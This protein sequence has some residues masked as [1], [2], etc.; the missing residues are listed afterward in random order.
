MF[1]ASILSRATCSGFFGGQQKAT[2]RNRPSAFFE[3]D[4]AVERSRAT[5]QRIRATL[6]KFMRNLRLHTLLPRLLLPAALLAGLDARADAAGAGGA[7]A[8][9]SRAD[10]FWQ[11]MAGHYGTV[12]SALVIL[13]QIAGVVSAIR[14]ILTARTSQGA[15]AWVVALLLLPYIAVPAYWVFGRS[16]FHG[17]VSLRRRRSA[18]TAPAIQAAIIHM[19]AQNMLVAPRFGEPFA[20]ER[21][22]N[23]PLT[24]ANDAEL[25]V[26]GEATFASIF[27]GIDR[28]RDYVLVQFY[29]IHDDATGRELLAR[30]AARAREGTRCFVLY[31]EL[32]SSGLTSRYVRDARAAGVAITKFNTRRGR[33]NRFQI[34]FRNHR[35]IV[36]VDGAEAWVGGLNVGDEYRGLD[37]KIGFWRDTHLR[38]AGPVVQCAQAAFVDDWHWATGEIPRLEWRPRAAPGGVSRVALCLPSAPSD[39]LETATLFFLD[40]INAARR[41]VWIATP[42]FVPDEQFISAL[43]LASLH[44]VDVRILIPDKA[45]N[46]LVQLSAWA[47]IEA[48]EAAGI[49]TFRYMKGFM[50]H[51]IVVVDDNYCTV[52]TANFDN[53]SFRLNFEMTMAFADKD[54]TAQVARMLEGDFAES[55]LATGSELRARGFW[56]RLAVRSAM[57]LA[58]VQ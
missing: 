1:S 39:E 20:V 56:R 55:R 37:K 10:G 4:F 40:A 51:K 33:W 17:Y 52:G 16:R 43:Q 53:R 57:L 24:C 36:I 9:L 15:V 12:I 54:F 26:N 48:L 2:E 47:Y 6:R 29:I 7:A 21:L 27:A 49:K 44:G 23:L 41:R 38:L 3:F 34:N 18:V 22:A 35:K 45:D 8:A 11:F 42:Y 19:R 46:F 31:D 32:G 58:P 14:A 5:A 30:L 50:H 28:A 25:L 13:A